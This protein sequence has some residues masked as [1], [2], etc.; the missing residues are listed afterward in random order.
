MPKVSV[1]MGVFN[2]SEFVAEAIESILS[3]TFSD[4]ELIICDDGSSDDTAAIVKKYAETDKRIVFVQNNR[5]YGLAHTLNHCLSLASGDYLIRMDGDDVSKPERF[6]VLLDTAER[7][8]EFDVIGSGVDLF[9]ENGVWGEAIFS[10]TPDKLD[11]FMQ[12]TLSHATVIMKRSAL[13]DCGA[14]DESTDI[15]RAEDY[16]LWCRMVLKGYRLTSIPD[17]LYQVRWDQR[18]YYSRRPFCVRLAWARLVKKWHKKMGLGMRGMNK[19]IGTYLKAFT[20]NA[21]KNLYHRVHFKVN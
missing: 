19:V 8:P 7:H 14:Y 5:N 9:D 12:R 17:K 13:A 15:A 6:Q 20:P 16:D 3:Q 1:L 2:C 21:I 10:N 11:A 18:N 4:F